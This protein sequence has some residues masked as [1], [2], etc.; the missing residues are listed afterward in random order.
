ME[1]A[2]R[3]LPSDALN[4]AD[5]AL[6]AASKTGDLSLVSALFK[7]GTDVNY[8]DTDGKTQNAIALAANSDTRKRKGIS[9]LFG[10]P[11]RRGR[12]K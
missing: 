10:R 4:N 11:P 3:C 9:P 6:C 5:V 7:V 12:S 1:D 8:T 2:C